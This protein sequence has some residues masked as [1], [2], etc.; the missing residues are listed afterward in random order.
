MDSW[1]AF[2][3]AVLDR[4]GV[5]DVDLAANYGISANRFYRRTTADGWDAPAPRVRT[6]PASTRSVQRQVLIVACATTHPAAASDRTAAWLHGLE[7]QPPPRPSVLMSH[8]TSATAASPAAALGVRR[9]RWLDRSDIVVVGGVPTL[10]VPALLVANA[11][12]PSCRIRAWLID[13]THRGLTTPT[14]VAD[15]LV[16]AG[17]VPGCGLLRRHCDELTGLTVE[18][19]FQDA[20]ADELERLGYEPERS[21]RRIPTADGHGLVIDVPLTHW[22]VAVEPDGDAFHRT[23]QQ[24]RRDRRRDA[25]FAGTDWVRVPIDWRD[26]L[27]ERDHVLAAIDAAIAAQ[28]R[29]GIGRHQLI[30]GRTAG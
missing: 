22:Q 6:H 13:A 19:I 26:W 25:A 5:A 18:S 9:A 28:Q 23:R 16:A 11:S 12:D 30:S 8:R 17:S 20:G 21:T 27:L 2:V 1:P 3:R 29:R 15:R 4:H 14:V 7:R 24:R 10:S